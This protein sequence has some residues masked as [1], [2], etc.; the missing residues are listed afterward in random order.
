MSN[1]KIIN[2]S[3]KCILNI[4]MPIVLTTL[5]ANLMY[6]TDRAMLA[7][8]SL[9]AMNAAMLGGNFVS[10]FAFLF[11]GI[12]NTAEIYVGQYNGAKQYEKMSTATWQMI[13]LSSLSILL[14]FPLAYF[15]EQ[16]NSFPEYLLADGVVYQKP[17]L[18]FG[19]LPVLIS[20]LSTF[21][22]GQ[23]K[24][25]IITFVIVSGSILNAVLDYFFI[26]GMDMGSK[27]AAYG[28]VIAEAFQVII[29][30]FVFFNKNNKNVYKTAKNHHFRAKLFNNCIKIGL[31]LAIGNCIILLAWYLI[32]AAFA[33]TSKELAIVYG[34]GINIYT[35]FIFIGEALNKAIATI[36]SN[37]IGQK[38]L[39]GIQ[40]TYRRF[41]FVAIVFGFIIAIP[42][43]IFPKS[44]VSLLNLLHDDITLL[45]PQIKVVLRWTTVSV[46]VES[47]MCITWG[48][49]LSGGDTRYPVIVNQICLW[50]FVV[51]P[52]WLLHYYNMLNTTVIAFILTFIW[53]FV[54]TIILYKRYR[55]LKWYNKLV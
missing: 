13:H 26:Y 52:T 55:S 32:H 29:L 4:T 5:S 3:F 28:T 15:T 53:G 23:G 24:T 6:V 38:N 40:K 25:K 9:N 30:I 11:I 42:L 12:A 16:L 22:I 21:F 27:G 54:V 51:I 48:V 17:L 14:F 46:V 20:A 43:L 1:H 44:I 36:S 41:V 33:Y 39:A 2:D 8:Y 49:L 50:A 18:Y 37:M 7:G 19:F 47:I 34:I 35:L 31:P 10:I 45:Y